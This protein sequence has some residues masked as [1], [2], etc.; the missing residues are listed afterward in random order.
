[1]KRAEGVVKGVNVSKKTITA[2]IS[3]LSVDREQEII[4]PKSMAKRINTYKSNPVLLFG[5]PI[6]RTS[7]GIADPLDMIGNAIDIQI[8]DKEVIAEF[9]YA[10]DF[11]PRAKFVFDMAQAGFYRAYSIGGF[12]YESV[13]ICDSRGVIER[14][15]APFGSAGAWCLEQMLSESANRVVTD[16]ELWETSQVFVGCNRQGLKKAAEKAISG[17]LMTQKDISAML[18][19]EIPEKVKKVPVGID[20]QKDA[21]SYYYRPAYHP[22]IA[23]VV[24]RLH[25]QAE[26]LPQ[27]VDPDGDGDIDSTEAISSCVIVLGA[28]IEQLSGLVPQNPADE[29]GETSMMEASVKEGMVDPEDPDSM[30]EEEESACT[31]APDEG[32]EM[33]SKALQDLK[34]IFSP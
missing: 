26:I 19:G 14:S 32:G 18:R 33:M 25:A 21:C 22:T 30:D 28:V 6:R 12:P 13:D 31:K 16:F 29:A 24:T 2:V 17:G 8:T 3:A 10:V 7:M 9:E 15:L 23:D 34:T 4:I 20:L 11:N 5:H 1:M 27:L